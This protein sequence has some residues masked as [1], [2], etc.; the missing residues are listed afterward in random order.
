MGRMYKLND[1]KIID[2]SNFH[3]ENKILYDKNYTKIIAILPTGYYRDLTIKEGIK[4]I[5]NY[6][7]YKC[8]SLNSTIFPSTLTKIGISSFYS[9][10]LTSILINENIETIDRYAFCDCYQLKE[11]NLFEV[12][13]KTLEYGIFSN[14]KLETIYLPKKLISMKQVVFE[15]NPLK[16]IF[17]YSNNPPDFYDFSSSFATF[18]NVDIKKCIV[19]APKGKFNIYKKAKG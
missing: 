5:Q 18:K 9:S 1:V 10:G 7:F 8:K 4:E 3:F 12:K 14:S 2:N 6:A 15:N 11:V 17:C 16:N 19:H 13:I